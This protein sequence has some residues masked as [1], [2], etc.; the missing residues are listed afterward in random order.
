MFTLQ[1]SN[2]PQYFKWH[3]YG[4]SLSA[5]KDIIFPSE[6][7][8]V[9]VIALAGGEFEFPEGCEL[10]SAVYI[11]DTSKSLQIPLTVTI[12][13]CVSLET[14]EQ[15]NSLQ[16]VRA[17]LNNGIPPYHFKFLS[18][19]RFAQGGQYGS[20]FC[21][22]FGG[23][24][25]VK[26]GDGE[27]ENNT[28]DEDYCGYQ[29]LPNSKDSVTDNDKAKIPNENSLQLSEYEGV[30]SYSH[31]LACMYDYLR[32]QNQKNRRVRSLMSWCQQ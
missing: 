18:G 9:A 27:G 14:R 21:L 28:S 2:L 5:S 25:I 16:F 11:I 3:S 4:I 15:C 32:L 31:I 8:E 26:K 17:S 30:Y 12:Q 1:K 22:Q 20:I 24:G 29:D 10:V 23:L 13:H 7:C 19:G 6:T